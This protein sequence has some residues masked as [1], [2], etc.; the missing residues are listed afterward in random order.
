MCPS[1]FS[2]I[3]QYWWKKQSPHDDM[4]LLDIIMTKIMHRKGR[5]NGMYMVTNSYKN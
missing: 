2:Q 1:R 4:Q 5:Q 3:T